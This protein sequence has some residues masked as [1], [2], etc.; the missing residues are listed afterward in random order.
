MG[1][2]KKKKKTTRKTHNRKKN[3]AKWTTPKVQKERNV[4][5]NIGLIFIVVGIFLIIFSVVGYVIRPD[6]LGDSINKEVVSDPLVQFAC[7]RPNQELTVYSMT[8]RYGENTM[9][10]IWKQDSEY[11][12]AKY[13]EITLW[14]WAS[15]EIDFNWSC[16]GEVQAMKF[17]D[18]NGVADIATELD[19]NEGTGKRMLF[20]LKF[21]RHKNTYMNVIRIKSEDYKA[22]NAERCTLR[23]PCMVSWHSVGKANERYSEG[24][25][26][27]KNSLES[28]GVATDDKDIINRNL[29]GEDLYLPLFNYT[30]TVEDLSQIDSN[31]RLE[32][33]D[34]LISENEHFMNQGIY[35]RWDG[36]FF[37]LPRVEY[38]VLDYDTENT[39]NSNVWLTI[40][41]LGFAL[42]LDGYKRK[43]E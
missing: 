8:D 35:L 32:N 24:A 27:S 43:R 37:F 39:F 34:E 31:Y 23:V 22:F 41:G 5:T 42:I 29:N 11:S 16:E 14:A 10:F 20:M 30:A 21:Y 17:Y 28:N 25:E 18:S 13:D 7:N 2:K 3:V 36:S 33:A 12:S 19:T 15:D 9:T 38:T 6:I 40:L 26:W 1:R 4:S